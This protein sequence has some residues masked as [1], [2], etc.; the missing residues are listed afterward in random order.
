[1]DSLAAR[2][3]IRVIAVVGLLQIVIGIASTAYVADRS[4]KLFD[5]ALR[6]QAEALSRTLG[7]GE[8]FHLQATG[9][10][11]ETARPDTEQRT[12]S[13]GTQ[14][15]FQYWDARNALRVSSDNFSNVRLDAAP[16]GFVDM[17]L[18]KHRWR[19]LTLLEGDR[20]IRVGQR[21]DVY[22]APVRSTA[23]QSLIVIALGL[24]LL[25]VLSRC[26]SRKGFEPI[27]EFAERIDRCVPG[28]GGPIGLGDLPQE[29]EPI[30][31]SVNAL[32]ARCRCLSPR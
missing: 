30:V 20:W 1:M 32:L 29:F 3:S 12:H 22:G 2:L 19:I 26:A 10:A 7:A 14:I 28:P 31:A 25:F 5:A 8:T 27:A 16:L 23:I 4:T 24:P 18:E 21:I 6:Q 11:A 13:H 17:Q 15:G 9:G